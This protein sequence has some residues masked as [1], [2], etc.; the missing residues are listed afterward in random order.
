MKYY[1]LGKI[2]NSMI[3]LQTVKY[4]IWDYCLTKLFEGFQNNFTDIIQDLEKLHIGMHIKRIITR[5]GTE[6]HDCE[7]YNMNRNSANTGYI[8]KFSFKYL[9]NSR[10]E[11]MENSDGLFML[12]PILDKSYIRNINNE[13]HIYE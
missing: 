5:H 10:N 9:S 4:L 7:I 1:L 12:F 2:T 6:Y 11:C 13:I 3:A 8:I